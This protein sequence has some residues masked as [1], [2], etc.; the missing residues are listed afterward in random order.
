MKYDFLIVGQGLAGSLLAYELLNKGY[1]I[2]IID[3]DDPN[4]SSKKA[5]GL[6]NPVTGRNMVVTWMADELF[7]ELPEYYEQLE[8]TLDSSFHQRIPIYRP[9]YSIEELND[10]TGKV[11][12][13]RFRPFVQKLHSRSLGI[14]G[15]ED[16]Y[17]GIELRRSG[18]VDLPVMLK[19]FKHYFSERSRIRTESFDYTQLL[20]NGNVTYKDIHAE[21]ILFC[22]GPF[23]SNNPW[24]RHLPF[25]PVRGEVIDIKCDLPSERI[26]NRGVFML[27]KEG[28]FR[29]GSTYDHTD[30]S[31]SPKEKGVNELQERMK[32]LFTGSYELITANAGVRPATADRRPYIGWH[33]ENKAVGIFNGFGTKGVSLVPYFS[34][35]FADAIK[36]NKSIHSEADV[37]RVF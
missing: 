16:P 31:F 5:A 13:P 21:R 23:V 20:L 4:T 28:F 10:W 6:Y 35:L 29:I 18:F 26:Y 25:K 24:W 33:P 17:G 19:A 22:D 2:C 3:P 27:P 11:D 34:K 9:F 8:K 36:G 32:K 12:D 1:S 15:L 37:R 7:A 30:L 14:S